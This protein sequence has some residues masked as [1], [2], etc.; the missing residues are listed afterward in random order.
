MSLIPNTAQASMM[1]ERQFRRRQQQQ[2][3]KIEKKFGK[4]LPLPS[5]D[6][7]AQYIANKTNTTFEWESQQE[8]K[9]TN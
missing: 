1:T 9:P 5:E 8:E 7:M 3:K 6:D 2:I 4:H